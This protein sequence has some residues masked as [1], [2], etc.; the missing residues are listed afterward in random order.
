MSAVDLVKVEYALIRASRVALLVETPPAT[1]ETLVRFLGQEDPL[2]EGYAAHSS[3]LGFP[4]WLR[5]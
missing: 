3:I 2:K 1:Q 4:W 5:W